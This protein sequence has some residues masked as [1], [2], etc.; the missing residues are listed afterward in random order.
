MSATEKSISSSLLSL[1]A[2]KFFNTKFLVNTR[3]DFPSRPYYNCTVFSSNS[4]IAL[5]EAWHRLLSSL[6]IIQ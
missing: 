3:V 2:R 4:E 1:I 5:L 6:F